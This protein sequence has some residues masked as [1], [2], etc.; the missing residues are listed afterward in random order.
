MKPSE[1]FITAICDSG[2]PVIDCG[3]CGKVHFA[4]GSHHCLKEDE[5]ADLRKKAEAEPTKYIEDSS[6]DSVRWGYLD[7]R[8]AVWNCCGET[9]A[10]YERWLISHQQKIVDFYKAFASRL[11][12]EASHSERMIDSL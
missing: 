1:E 6:N 4:T 2:S 9:L 11:R 3:F 5:L 12:A 10:R 7:G 8:Q